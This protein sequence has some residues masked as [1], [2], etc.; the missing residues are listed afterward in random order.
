MSVTTLEPVNEADIEQGMV[1][2]IDV[3]SNSVRLVVFEGRPRG[4][5]PIFNE[6][7]LCGLGRHLDRTGRLDRRG[8]ER[9]RETLR[10]F[11]GLADRMG[12]SK[13]QA[14]A[15]AAVRDAED[16]A[17]FVDAVRRDFG[18]PI[19]IVSGGEEARL[20][21][22][23]VLYG[24][25][26]ADGLVADLGGG[27]LEVVALDH[28]K[29]RQTATLPL[30]PLRLERYQDRRD[31]R[32]HV[33]DQLGRVEWLALWLDRPLYLIGGAW[34]SM[35][36]ITMARS[37]YFLE[38]I[39]NYLV[40][41]AGLRD[42]AHLISRQSA[43]SLEQIAGVSTRRLDTL[44]DSALVLHRLLK[45]TL[46]SRAIFSGHGLREGLLFDALGDAERRR[47]PLIE[48]CSAMAVQEN[49]FAIVGQELFD[50]MAPLFPTEKSTWARLRLAACLLSDVAWRVHPDHRDHQAYRRILR[51]PIP[52]I[53]HHGRAAIALAIFA[54]YKGAVT[55]D[56]LV[57]AVR[58][59]SEADA[60][61]VERIGLALRLAHTFSGGTPGAIAA[62]ELEV[63]PSELIF[64]VGRAVMHLTGETVQRRLDALA[65]TFDKKGVVAG[66]T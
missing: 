45:A 36:R 16:G 39:D 55:G 25:P 19:T 41:P 8:I 52:G 47:D 15:T 62:T 43:E 9:A 48:A 66:L 5:L 27:S 17:E 21:G 12:V 4:R 54:R 35:A 13:L 58:L 1:G 38:I 50:W 63:G 14:V 7:V 32:R 26:D 10:R 20:V 49:R 64:R 18:L 24:I 33:D 57:P 31:L 40:D 3:G 53:D 56:Q 44:P 28:G 59:L 46:P 6:K 65:R 2:V 61:K 22:Q 30:G 34:R 23:G 51:A 37:G 29:V 42:L 60:A 11:I